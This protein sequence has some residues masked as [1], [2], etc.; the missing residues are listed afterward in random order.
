MISRF[1]QTPHGRLHFRE[2]GKG[3]PVLMLPT[4]GSSAYQY[5][6]VAEQLASSRRVISVDYPGHGDSDPLP[7]HYSIE[8]YGDSILKL[9]DALQLEQFDV[10]GS[11][12]G[13]VIAMQLARDAAD[14][15][16]TVTLVD[17]PVRT[18]AFW[19]GQWPRIELA[20]GLP[21]VTADSLRSK[22]RE[23]TE[24]LVSRVHVDRV[25]AGA[26]TMVDAMWAVRE[27]DAHGA[28][29]SL[30]RKPCLVLIGERG[31]IA[32]LAPTY[33]SS[34]PAARTVVMGNCGHFPMT[35]DPDA[36]AALVGDFLKP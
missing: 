13:G 8:E 4:N 6:A 31:P 10:L 32:D 5:D 34:L 23:L 9:A 2:C 36:F 1:A 29:R 18:E 15:V 24:G 17:T 35:D 26:K 12:I 33:R 28:L 3:A 22:Y 14:R 27:F 21:N 11:S 19:A 16:R 20:F 25:K 7:R 30:A